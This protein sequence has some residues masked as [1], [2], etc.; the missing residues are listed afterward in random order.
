MSDMSDDSDAPAKKKRNTDGRLIEDKD[1]LRARKAPTFFE[2]YF[3][4]CKW[5]SV[6]NIVLILAVQE[7]PRARGSHHVAEEQVE[8]EEAEEQEATVSLP[9]LRKRE[10]RYPQGIGQLTRIQAIFKL[11]IPRSFRAFFRNDHH[12]AW[13]FWLR[14]PADARPSAFRTLFR[15]WLAR[16]ALGDAAGER[17]PVCKYRFSA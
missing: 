1:G 7:P 9:R 5:N 16:H 14:I 3:I 4:R 15:R 11:T 13:R 17:S 8:R 10:I 2:Y 6:G 12:A